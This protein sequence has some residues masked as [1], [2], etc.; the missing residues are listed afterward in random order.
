MQHKRNL[1][2]TYLRDLDM[3]ELAE[4]ASSANTARLKELNTIII[5][6]MFKIPPDKRFGVLESLHQL[7]YGDSQKCSTATYKRYKTYR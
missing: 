6:N 2:A 5:R 4:E 1:V 7:L 3:H